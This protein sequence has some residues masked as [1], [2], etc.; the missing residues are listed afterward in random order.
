VD[1]R[2][3]NLGKLSG[4][5]IEIGGCGMVA[6]NVFRN[7]GYAEDSVTGFAFGV[8]TERLAMLLYGVDDIRLFFQNDTRFLRQFMAPMLR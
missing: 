4:R 5:W 3:N 8:G 7:C 6:P 1:F 2:S